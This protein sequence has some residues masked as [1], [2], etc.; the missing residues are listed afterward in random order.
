LTDNVTG[1]ARTILS[2]KILGASC[3]RACPT[4]VL[5]EGACVMLD[6]DSDPIKIGR[7]Q[8]YAI[9]HVNENQIAVLRPA[10]KKSGRCM[11]IIGGGPAGLGCAEE[12][13]Q[14]EHD[15]VHPDGSQDR[16]A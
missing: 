15:A 14:L 6:R 10:A 7:L 4:E 11:A 13:S 3:A 8:R 2:A 16:S 9:D 1:A 5:C 12:L